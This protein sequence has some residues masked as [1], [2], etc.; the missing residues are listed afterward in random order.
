MVSIVQ[1]AKRLQSQMVKWRRHIHMHPEI[2]LETPKTS[3]LI[4]EVLQ[5]AGLKVKQKVA[6]YGVIGL[7]EGS[8]SGPTI[9][10]RADIDALKVPEQTGLPFASTIPGLM[11]ACGHDGHVAIALGAAIILNRTKDKIKGNVKFI[12]QP[13]EEGPGGALP[14]IE[15]GALEN[16]KVDAVIGLH[17]GNLWEVPSGSIGVKTGAMMAATDRLKV[18]VKGEGGHG[19]KPHEAIDAVYV[20]AQIVN[21]LQSIVSRRISPLDSVVVT[22]GKF[23]GGTASNV[24]AETAVLEATIRCLNTEL[25]QKLP[26]YL[27][28]VV[29]GTCKSMGAEYEFDYSLGYPVLFNDPSFTK[30][31]TGIAQEVLGKEHVMTLSEPSMGGEDMAFFLQQVP[32]TFFFL[33]S[34][35]QGRKVYPHHSPRFDIDESVLWIGA[36]LFAETAVR[37]LSAEG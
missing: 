2:G 29:N 7:V 8:S 13:G 17:I 22:V 26:R 10:I 24:I 18:T 32:G 34:R 6:G 15:D 28:T 20:G 9:A 19:A 12:F 23:Q 37:W 31:F 30:F 5:Q 33:G 36:A 4:A 1:E 14:M 11:H 25:H 16:P 27:E 3:G 35:P 21:A